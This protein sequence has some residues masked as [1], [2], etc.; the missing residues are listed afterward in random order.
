MFRVLVIEDDPVQALQLVD[1]IKE[2]SYG[3]D[4]EVT[5]CTAGS[6]VQLQKEPVDVLFCDIAF[7]KGGLDGVDLVIRFFADG[8]TQVVYVTEPENYSER[9]YLTDHAC[10]LM[11]PVD[12]QKLTTALGMALS[13][14][15]AKA[16]GPLRLHDGR[17][18]HLV[19]PDSII[20]IESDRRILYFHTTCG[21]IRTYGRL[22]D[23]ASKLPK[24]FLQTH[25]SYLVNMDYIEELHQDELKMRGGGVSLSP[26]VEGARFGRPLLRT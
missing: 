3:H 18:E 13:R 9:V 10:L 8:N 4:C 14:V 2:S 22:K 26:S 1:G 5:V 6:I 21:V 15:E 7:A 24:R 12:Q 20:Y 25:R 11:K 23:A 16:N 19:S 17:T